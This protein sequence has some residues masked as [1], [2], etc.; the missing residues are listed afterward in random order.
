M[1][2]ILNIITPIGS[3][4]G[5]DQTINSVKK[6]SSK[7]KSLKF[8]HI[9]VL[10][11][12]VEYSILDSVNQSTNLITNIININPI[13]SR[14]K[15]R[16]A[17]LRQINIITGVSSFV[18]FL[19]AGDKL[20]DKAIKNITN[21]ETKLESNNRLFV[22]QSYIEL[23]NKAKLSKIPLFPISFRKIVN[24]FL[25]GGIILS[26]ELAKKI[27][28]YEGKKEDWVYW[29][30][31]LDLQPEIHKTNNF[32]YIYKIDNTT[33]HYKNKY[34]SIKELRKILVNHLKWSG[35]L[36]YLVFILHFILITIR[37]LYI[38]LKNKI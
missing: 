7:I 23:N 24:P 20:L 37:W 13:A 27:E 18:I 19:D 2:I 35:I 31:I 5:L 10:N 15:A 6:V 4:D 36:S 29:N 28:F 34:H 1:D 8:N 14:S 38:N 21:L 26:S 11:N 33:K 3:L 32:N 16:N 25:L 9:L 30:S 22:N 17:A 12:S